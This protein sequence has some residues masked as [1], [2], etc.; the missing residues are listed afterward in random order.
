MK[1]K[2]GHKRFYELLDEIAQLHS[3]KSHDYGGKD[4]LSNLREFGWK[5]V[6]VRLGDKYCRLR[7]FAKQGELKVKDESLKDTLMDNAVYSLL[8]I[9]LFEE[10]NK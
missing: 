8:A 10:E 6:I 4:P 2:Y 1:Y 9:V 7:N 5:G 3:S